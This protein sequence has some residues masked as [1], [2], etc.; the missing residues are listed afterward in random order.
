MITLASF[1]SRTNGK[2]TKHFIF[3][4]KNTLFGNLGDESIEKGDKRMME[5]ITTFIGNLGR[6]KEREM[7]FSRLRFWGERKSKHI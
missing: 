4:N 6:K 3:K 2:M 5:K 7:F 1:N